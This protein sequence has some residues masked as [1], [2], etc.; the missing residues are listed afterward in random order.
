MNNCVI[1]LTASV[2]VGDITNT[3]YK[4]A[5]LRKN[6]YINSL[7][8]YLSKINNK[9][10]FV[11]NTNTDLSL[12]FKE[13]IQSGRLEIL[14]FDGNKFNPLFGKSFG[15]IE[16]IEFALNNSVILKSS[17]YIIKITGRYQI[18]NISKLQLLS[19]NYKESLIG[20]F[21]YRQ[22]MM[23]SRI[24][25]GSKLFYTHFLLSYKNMIDE[26]KGIY[27]EHILALACFK[28]ISNPHY[29]FIEF[30]HLPRIHG[31]FATFNKRYNSGLIYYILRNFIFHIKKYLQ[32]K[33]N[34]N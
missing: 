4:S 1:L 21:F 15:E 24:F 14:T 3:K 20:S 8:F 16:I 19:N 32:Y 12:I 28:F 6:D 7:F 34:R 33:L 9:I 5:E 18:L 25:L 31:T 22:E 11:E 23:D 26:S 27:F 10:V 30:C 17:Y 29:R 13:F 2:N